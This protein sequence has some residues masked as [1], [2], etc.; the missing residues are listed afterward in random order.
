MA[1][2][3]RRMP[4]VE[5]RATP[6]AANDNTPVVNDNA[7]TEVARR[8]A[9]QPDTTPHYRITKIKAVFMI[10]VAGIFDLLQVAAKLFILLG[11]AAA[12]A[13]AGS[14]LGNFIGLTET[15]AYVGGA[16]G[17]L[18]QF[19]G[20]GALLSAQIGMLLS[21]IFSMIAAVLGYTTLGL[22]FITNRV[23]ILGGEKAAEKTSWFVI[24]GLIS[25]MPL[26]NIIP[27]LTFWTIR[28]IVIS[29]RVDRRRAKRN[30]GAVAQRFTRMARRRRG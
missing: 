2:P 10:A 9:T 8:R 28:M 4:V 18:L 27:A 22:W 16:V 23:S 5:P 30:S 26:L 14:I 7:A 1:L 29:R 21:W 19:T 24:T 17:G 20:P 11:L 3:A 25:I 13:L 15:G 6:E 12:G